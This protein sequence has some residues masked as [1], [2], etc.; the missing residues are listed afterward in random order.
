MSDTQRQIAQKLQ[1]KL[2]FYLIALAF[3]V[4]ALA[5]QT[6]EFGNYLISDITELTGWLSLLLSG[7]VGLI[8]LEMFPVVYNKHAI[9]NDLEHE[10]FKY[11]EIKASGTNVVCL[12]LEDAKEIPIDPLISDRKTAI[13]VLKPVITNLEM[14][15]ITRYRF[16]KWLLFFGITL[17]SVSRSVPGFL[18]VMNNISKHLC[19]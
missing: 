8:R 12:A 18:A 9:L 14:K 1:E 5:V 4:L 2:E 11:E 10:I 13:E 16:H 7:L 17:I 15:I 19:H 3:T 6:V